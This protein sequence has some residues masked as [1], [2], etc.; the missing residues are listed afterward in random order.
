MQPLDADV[1]FKKLPRTAISLQLATYYYALQL[2][3]RLNPASEDH[4]GALYTHDPSDVIAAMLAATDDGGAAVVD[5]GKSVREL[6]EKLH[7]YNELLADFTQAQVLENLC[8]GR[9]CEA[10]GVEVQLLVAL[11][12]LVVYCHIVP[13]F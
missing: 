7:H 6:V 3:M 12:A 13:G 9:S 11:Q 4:Q 5:A 2:G 10:K 1:V 8:K